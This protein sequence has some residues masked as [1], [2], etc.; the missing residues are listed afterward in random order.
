M[1]LIRDWVAR[2]IARPDEMEGTDV[3]APTG[4]P[5]RA[6]AGQAPK[7]KIATIRQHLTL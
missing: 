7:A 5:P 2:A 1:S 3:S 4:G 6:A